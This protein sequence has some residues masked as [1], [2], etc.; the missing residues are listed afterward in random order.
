M[1]ELPPRVRNALYIVG[2]P[3]KWAVLDCPC[4]CGERIVVNL[5]RKSHAAMG[6]YPDERHRDVI[7]VALYAA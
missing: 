6:A 5:M 1:S 7:P 4:R 2:L 3:A